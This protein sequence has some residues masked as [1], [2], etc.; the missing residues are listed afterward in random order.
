MA[1]TA[2]QIAAL[3]GRYTNSV[4]NEQINSETPV[5][6]KGVLKKV[7]K[8]DKIG[9]VNVKAGEL[10]S[11]GF[12]ADGGTLP[13]GS[14]VAPVQGNYLPVGLF[15]R[16][17]IPRIA[18]SLASSVDDGIDIV[19]EE[20]D[21]CGK[22]MGRLLGR[23][24]FGQSLGAPAATVAIASSSFEVVSPAGWRVGMAFEVYNGGTAVE[25]H[26]EATLLRVTNVAIPADGQ[27][28]STVS[29]SAAG[30]GGNT[31]QWLTSYSF[32]LRGSKTN[33][34]VSLQ[35]ITAAASLYSISNTTQ[36]WQANLDSTTATLSIPAMRSLMTTVVR[37]RGKKPSHVLCNRRNEERYSNQLINNRR[38]MS[39]KMDAVGGASF[40]F[41]GVPVFTD[42]NID[43]NDL[44]FFQQDDVKLHVFKDA[45]PEFDGGESKGMNRGAVLVSDSQLIY[46]V[47]V[48]GIYNVRC[49]RRNGLGRF[50]ALAG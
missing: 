22:T 12:I 18:A 26:T 14:E 5:V 4:V 44:Y 49:E 20:M 34:M 41:E 30:G 24:I 47:Q 50:S 11:G 42:E 43:D 10:S 37:R 16:I 36:D 35:D 21:S 2:S 39:G 19:K 3:V 33:A 32:H 6:G 25:G 23:G 7:K 48:L 27:G 40:E 28:N 38:F 31:V 46:D 15:A 9:I 8:K 1:I 17:S 45:A 13:V 29:F